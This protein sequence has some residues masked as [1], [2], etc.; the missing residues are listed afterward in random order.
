MVNFRANKAVNWSKSNVMTS[1]TIVLGASG[2]LGS[3]FIQHEYP[4]VY[5]FRT[6]P[7]SSIPHL[8]ILDPWKTDEL[9]KVIV[10][11]ELDS[12]INCIALANIE[13]CES[14]EAK[15]FEIN[16]ELPRRLAELCKRRSV[17]LVHVS[18]DAVL[19]DAKGLLDEGSLT[20][21]KSVYGKSKLLGE[22]QVLKTSPLFTVARVN[23]F[24]VSPRRDSLFDF[25]YNSLKQGNVV[26][27]FS[28]IFFSPLYVKDTISA[29]R[30]LASNENPGIVHLA[31]STPISKY[32]FG[33]EVASLLG[34]STELIVETRARDL[35]L[36]Q[37]RSLN[38][39]I[40]NQKMLTFYQPQFSIKEGI[41]A[42]IEQRERGDL[43]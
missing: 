2:F 20:N 34:L 24:G 5:Q 37:L 6:K 19:Q 3:H 43:D 40:N 18:T 25:F 22:E 28:D 13:D 8:L 15:A 31:S 12:L 42:C 38:L 21:P 10:N 9:E 16:S 41:L 4:E 30:Y 27:G 32:E 33:L 35:P 36:G 29:L 23:F 17:H 1:K 39:S 7:E 26:L 11:H 14:N